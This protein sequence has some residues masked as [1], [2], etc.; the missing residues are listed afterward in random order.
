M[1][2]GVVE[3]SCWVKDCV[4]CEV[5]DL[6]YVERNLGRTL[7]ASLRIPWPSQLRNSSSGDEWTR[8]TSTSLNSCMTGRISAHPQRKGQPAT[9]LV[10]NPLPR[11]RQ[12]TR[13]HHLRVHD[14][15]PDR[16]EGQSCNVRQDLSQS[17]CEHIE[18]SRRSRPAHNGSS[19]GWHPL[20][21]RRTYLL[22]IRMTGTLT[23]RDRIVGNQ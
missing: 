3:G 18:V 23:P 21:R 11:P 9:P 20:R 15:S 10:R 12:R 7:D 4:L 13:T 22:P 2:T 1:F 17:P 8:R 5:E 14:L 6:G 16:Y 19:Q